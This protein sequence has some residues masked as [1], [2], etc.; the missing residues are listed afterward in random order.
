MI[1]I[2]KIHNILTVKK[3]ILTGQQFIDL[4]SAI[5]LLTDGFIFFR[6]ISHVILM[7]QCRG[8]VHILRV[9]ETSN[10]Y[11]RGNKSE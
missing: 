9:D 11:I 1:A 7:S 8:I 5:E 3:I 4:L 10:E 6:L 2:Q